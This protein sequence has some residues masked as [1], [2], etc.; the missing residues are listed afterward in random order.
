MRRAA[1]KA[2][3]FEQFAR[4]LLK[5][6]TPRER[7]EAPRERRYQAERDLLVAVLSR[8]FP[9]H[10]TPVNQPS[11]AWTEVVCIHTPAGQLAW[12]LPPERMQWFAHLERT[13]SDWDGHRV[14]ER[15]ARLRKL[16]T[17]DMPPAKS[18]PKAR[19]RARRKAGEKK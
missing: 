6:Q 7:A 16:L 3:Q 5:V 14:S 4:Q 17:I 8:F 11:L 2:Q 12:G 19:R 10:I 13:A 1:T 15:D 9:S 18:T